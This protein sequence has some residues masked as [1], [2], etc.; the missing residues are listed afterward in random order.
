MRARKATAASEARNASRSLPPDTGRRARARALPS[1]CREPEVVGQFA[2]DIAA[3][4]SDAIVALLT[5]DAWL[6]MPPRPFEYQGAVAIGDF[7]EDRAVRRGARSRPAPGSRQPGRGRGHAN[8]NVR[9]RGRVRWA[10]CDA[11]GRLRA[12]GPK[13]DL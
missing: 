8:Q 7:R 12:D 4:D 2:D 13:P 3:G 9:C 5:G 10:A 11:P 1:S 6:K